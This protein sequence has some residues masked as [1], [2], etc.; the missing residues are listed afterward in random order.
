[1]GTLGCGCYRGTFLNCTHVTVSLLKAWKVTVVWIK[2]TMPSFNAIPE[3]TYHKF[4]A[5]E[6]NLNSASKVAN[7]IIVDILKQPY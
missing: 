2:C 6:K 7:W 5:Q 1:M 4:L 3:G